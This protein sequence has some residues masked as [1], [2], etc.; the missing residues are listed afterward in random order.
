M[1]TYPRHAPL[2]W[3]IM[4][5]RHCWVPARKS[6]AGLSVYLRGVALHVYLLFGYSRAR[7]LN[8]DFARVRLWPIAALLRR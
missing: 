8:H 3:R 6:T 2:V 7:G 5:R 1:N 4:S